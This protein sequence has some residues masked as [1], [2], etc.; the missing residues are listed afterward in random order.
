M[1]LLLTAVGSMS[2]ACA[3]T[4]LKEQGHTVYGCDI[5]PAEWHYESKLCD[6]IFLAPKALDT[7][8]YIGFL[9][10][11]CERHKIDAVIP[12]TDLEIDV[13][14]F[15]RKEFVDAGILLCMQDDGVLDIVRDKYELFRFFAHDAQVPTV[16]TFRMSDDGFTIQ[17]PCVAKPC[18]GRSSEG[19]VIARDGCALKAI[20]NPQ[21]YIVQEFLE[22]NIY[23]VDYIRNASSGHDMSIVR[24]E[25]LR[26]KNGAGLSVR[27]VNDSGLQSL[28]S[29][30]GGK[31]GING[32]VNLEFIRRHGDYYLIDCNPRFSAGISFSVLSGYD[33]VNS[34]LNC[35][36]GKDIFPAVQIQE[37][38]M[39][40]RYQ[41]EIL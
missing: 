14:K 23:T 4:K 25:L 7:E 38:Y 15:R 28:V 29:Y 24:E 16:Q 19:L 2:A 6:E 5:F 36:T 11:V 17:Y 41:E 27:I 33:M 26:T 8:K 39:T 18:N 3:I 31:L 21:N 22:G 20:A 30:I 35:F 9:L 40:K 34:H 13:I 10:S 12:L 32:C 37:K 1:R